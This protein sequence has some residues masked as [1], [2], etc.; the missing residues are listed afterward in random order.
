MQFD[1]QSADCGLNIQCLF[2]TVGT[3]GQSTASL[4]VSPI[5]YHG[6]FGTIPLTLLLVP[7]C[8][9]S[10]HAVFNVSSSGYPSS[11]Y[12]NFIVETPNYANIM[13]RIN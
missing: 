11:H 3:V 12:F 9:Y 8:L 13:S 6:H 4:S 10:T 5:I 2:P 1:Y 7:G